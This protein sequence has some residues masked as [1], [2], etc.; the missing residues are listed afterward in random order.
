MKEV[1]KKVVRVITRL[2]VG[3]PAKHVAWLSNGLDNLEWDNVLLYGPIEENEDDMS[4]LCVQHGV[5]MRLVHE[6]QREIDLTKDVVS[7]WRAFK[8]FKKEN[9]SIIHTHTAKG[10]MVGRTAAILYKLLYNRKVK[11]VHTFHGH[12]F[13]GYFSKAKQ[14]TFLSVERFLAATITDK[15]ITISAAQ[16]KEILGRFKVGNK[17]KHVVINLGIDTSFSTVLDKTALRS[18]LGIQSDELVVGIVGRIAPIKHHSLFVKTAH[19]ANQWFGGKKKLRFVI[20]G[21]GSSK[22]VGDLKNLAAE[23]KVSNLVFAGNQSN[24]ALF[25]G[26]LDVL[27]LTSKNEGTP[28][29]ILEAFAAKIPVV[30][31]NVGGVVDLLGTKSERGKLVEQDSSALCAALIDTIENDQQK[32]IEEAQQFVMQHY[33]IKILVNK[34]QKLYL[35]LLGQT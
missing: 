31:T 7:V 4:A 28:V 5:D 11:I 27:M 1:N 29:S 35:E 18:N 26:A 25:Y 33:S 17:N 13:H 30:A 3:G 14:L 24:P 23:L 34:I 2:N 9:P 8:V 32:Q 15:I 16:Q 21:E 19:E 12:S 20:I 10:G 6:M 22:D